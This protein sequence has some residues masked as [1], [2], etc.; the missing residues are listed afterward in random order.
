MSRTSSWSLVAGKTHAY[1]SVKRACLFTYLTLLRPRIMG[2]VQTHRKLQHPPHPI[3]SRRQHSRRDADLSHL[4]MLGATHTQFNT[5][6]MMLRIFHIFAAGSLP[7][8]RWHASSTWR[9]C[10][11]PSA[12]L[13]FS[14]GRYPHLFLI[15]WEYR[16][17]LSF[18]ISANKDTTHF[19]TSRPFRFHL[20]WTPSAPSSLHTSLSILE[21]R[22]SVQVTAI[23]LFD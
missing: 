12:L 10:Y 11:I 22:F 17:T 14:S 4:L 13:A 2:S 20:R 7:A 1:T 6:D 21:L 18:H 3:E 5:L 19:T 9:R 23:S 15:L 16:I 8:R